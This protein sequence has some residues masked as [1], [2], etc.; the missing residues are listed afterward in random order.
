MKLNNLSPRDQEIN[1][2]WGWGKRIFFSPHPH[3]EIISWSRGEKDDLAPTPTTRQSPGL[4]VISL[5]S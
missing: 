3:H 2:W 4:V 5:K 1:S